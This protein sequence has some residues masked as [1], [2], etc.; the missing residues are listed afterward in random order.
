MVSLTARQKTN[1]SGFPK[2]GELIEITGAHLLD[3][4]DRAIQ[5]KLFQHAHDS[6]RLTDRDADWELPLAELRSCLSKH[7]G[8]ERVRASLAKLMDVKVVVHYAM[9]KTGEPRTLKTHLLDFIDTSDADGGNATV[10]Y[11]LPKDLR[12]V[13]A[14]SNRWGRVKCEIT[15]AMTSKYAMALYELICLR[16]NMDRCL[17]T[18]T[19][20]R[21]RDLLGVPPGAY[22]NGKDFRLK[23]VDPA[24]LEVNGLSDLGVQIELI[25][26]HPRA[27]AGEVAITWW[28]KQGDEFQAAHRELNQSKAGRM[29]RLRGKVER[30]TPAP[31]ALVLP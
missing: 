6:G 20:E 19:L 18:F 28:K 25:R 21:F 1:H 16:A 3:A 30:I 15:Y 17:E 31:L 12:A 4:P 22:A 10:R 23:V 14:R 11:G 9:P 26:R 24:V 7:E 29:A 2:A 5:N 27:A 8:N 13:L